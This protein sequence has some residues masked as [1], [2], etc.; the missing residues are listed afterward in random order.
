M[1]LTAIAGALVLWVVVPSI[2][3]FFWSQIAVTIVHVGVMRT[4]LW[5]QLPHSSDPPRFQP[6]RFLGAYRFAVGMTG[7]TICSLVVTQ[8]DKIVLSRMLTLEAFGYYSL[9]SVIGAPWPR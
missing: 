4:V 1:T 5:R 6:A 7:I 8:A 9:A 2:T 3:L